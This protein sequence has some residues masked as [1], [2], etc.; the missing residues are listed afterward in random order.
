[1]R[2]ILVGS[3]AVIRFAPQEQ[4]IMKRS[5]WYPLTK[6]FPVFPKDAMVETIG[7]HLCGMM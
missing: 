7:K 2:P 3:S 1:M 6:R 5:D 4:N